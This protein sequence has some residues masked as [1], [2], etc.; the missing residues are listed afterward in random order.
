DMIET[1]NIFHTI[2]NS[3][4]LFPYSD[5]QEVFHWTIGNKPSDIINNVEN[6]NTPY[7]VSI[8][9]NYN[10]KSGSI[11]LKE[12]LNI[13]GGVISTPYYSNTEFYRAF[14]YIYFNSSDLNV[15]ISKYYLIKFITTQISNIDKISYKDENYDNF[16]FSNNFIVE[17]D[18]KIIEDLGLLNKIDIKLDFSKNDRY[19]IFSIDLIKGENE[20][21]PMFINNNP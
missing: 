3:P 2:C 4:D 10:S 12:N 6:I 9:D 1:S 21:I 5:I 11:L 18:I 7:K 17:G 16:Y 15:Y 20:Y 8:R 13:S 19:Q 14:F